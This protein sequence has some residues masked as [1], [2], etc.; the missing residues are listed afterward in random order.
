MS[1]KLIFKTGQAEAKLKCLAWKAGWGR[2]S[3]FLSSGWRFF[4][5]RGSFIS[6]LDPLMCFFN[7]SPSPRE[8]GSRG[9]LGEVY[10]SGCQF[11]SIRRAYLPNLDLLQCLEHFKK[12]VVGGWWVDTT[13]NIVFCFWPRLNLSWQAGPSKMNKMKVSKQEIV[14]PPTTTHLNRTS[15]WYQFDSLFI[16][17]G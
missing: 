16:K 7:L 9:R 10:S 8:I 1:S 6:I 3:L 2:G 17:K 12:F 5:L 15:P 14:K 4:R 11:L 13:V